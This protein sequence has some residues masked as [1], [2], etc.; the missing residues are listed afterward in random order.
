MSEGARTPHRVVIFGFYGVQA[1]DVVGP[2]DVFTRAA[3]LTGGGYSVTI[4]SRSGAPVPAESGLSF[5]TTVMPAPEA[6]DILVLPGGPGVHAARAHPEVMSWIEA[7]ARRA[8]RVVAVCGGAFFLAQIGLLDGCRT[9]THWS[10]ARRLA[11]EFPNV[12]VDS[13]AIVQR[14]TP[15]VWTTAGIASGIDVALALVEDDFGADVARDV[16]RWLVLHRCHPAGHRH[17]AAPS[18]ARQ[19]TRDCIRAALAAIDAEPGGKH[20]VS[21]LARRA[22]MSPRHFTRVFATEVGET[23]AVYV[24][25]VRVEAA[26][27]DL[28]ESG[29]TVARIAARRGFGT[30]ETLRRSFIRHNGVSPDQYRRSLDV[31]DNVRD[32]GDGWP[33]NAAADRLASTNDK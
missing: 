16:A 3:D 33:R 31:I 7:A 5:L 32:D 30:A 8:H 6:V 29:D 15:S 2:N 24:E 28:E 13:E 1:L 11:C 22:A 23:P 21:E 10:V 18:S 19:A 14:S 27:R 25:R 12:E 26:R 20:T 4:A 9:A 17:L